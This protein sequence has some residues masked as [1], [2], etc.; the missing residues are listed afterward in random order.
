[1]TTSEFG[2]R[3]DAGSGVLVG[4]SIASIGYLVFAYAIGMIVGGP[5]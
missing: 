4:V 2:V 3:D 5:C 1:M